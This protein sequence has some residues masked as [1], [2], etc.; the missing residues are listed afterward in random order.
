MLAHLAD[1]FQLQE[2]IFRQRGRVGA[3]GAPGEGYQGGIGGV[4]RF[5]EGLGVCLG[6]LKA[7][8]ESPQPQHSFLTPGFLQG[9]PGLGVSGFPYRWRRD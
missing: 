6:S 1:P 7:R 5:G 2:N 3:R 4:H 9:G 8:A